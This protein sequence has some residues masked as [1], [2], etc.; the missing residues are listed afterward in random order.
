MAPPETTPRSTFLAVAALAFV[1]LIWGITPVFIRSFA[2]AAGA[3]DSLV[4]RNALVS[5]LFLVFLPF[6]GGYHIARE[7]W[8]RLALVSLVGMLGYNIG[9]VFG[10]S[11]APAGIGGLI[12]ATQPLLIA[13]L[14]AM[15]G[16]EK[17][18][19]AAILGLTISFIG[20]L[21]LFQDD[22]VS[23]IPRN[24]I[25]IGSA[26]IFL[27]GLAWSVYVVFSKPLI[28]RKAPTRSAP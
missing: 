4:I 1:I 15:V 27:A 13:V 18:G 12:I 11:Y 16:S 28:R 20:S 3:A 10:F 22:G 9:S 17:L 5:A 26:L 8:S 2:L 23:Q 24:E 25:L 19:A 21:F 6:F 7:D 14:A